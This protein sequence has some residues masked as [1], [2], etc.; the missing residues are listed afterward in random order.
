M[1]RDDRDELDLFID[2]ELASPEFEAAY[3][4]ARTRSGLLRRLVSRRKARSINQAVVADR[5][6]TTQSAVSELENGGTDPRLSTVQRY[7]RAIGCR[8]DV[9]LRDDGGDWRFSTA[10]EMSAVRMEPARQGCAW[11]TTGSRNADF[12][13]SRVWATA[14]YSLRRDSGHN[15]DI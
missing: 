7:A 15:A 9:R 13:G 5:M 2:D 3:E 14:V 8:L 11:S 6:E 10:Y 12:D 4:D 1:S